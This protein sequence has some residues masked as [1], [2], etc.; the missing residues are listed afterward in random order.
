MGMS[1]K[2]YW[3]INYFYN[4]CLYTV[5]VLIFVIT[6]LI[7]KVRF[8]TQTRYEMSST[9]ILIIFS[10]LLLFLL[11]FIWGHT[12]ISLSFFFTVFFKRAQTASSTF[13]TSFWERSLTCI[14]FGYLLVVVSVVAGE[15]FNAV[16]KS[17]NDVWSS[18]LYWRFLLRY[19]SRLFQEPA[20]IVQ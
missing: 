2:T 3:A 18:K 9:C 6:E 5:V 7:F 4:Y 16:G 10:P 14:V 19:C 8:F 15:I 12:M 13:L 1:M 17:Y 11:F 20:T